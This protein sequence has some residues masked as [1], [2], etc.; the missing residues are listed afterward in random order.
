MSHKGTI[1]IISNTHWH[2]AWQTANSV[3]A[4]LAS[5][6]YKVLFI[7][8]IPKRWPKVM[9][10]SRVIGRAFGNARM[11]GDVEQTIAAGVN[12]ISP[13]TLPDVGSLPHLLNHR[14]FVPRL[15]AKI[16]QQANRPLVVMHALPIKAAVSLQHQLQ[17]DVSIYRCTYDWS[18]DPHSGRILAER[19]LLEQ[20]DM[21]WADCNHNLVR[22]RRVRPEAALM[23]P[24]VELSLFTAVSYTKSNQ[25][26]PLCVYFG[27]LGLSLDYQLLKQIS[28]GYKLRLIGPIRHPLTGFSE[29]TELVGP[30]PHE[31]IPRLI[32]DA[33]VLLLPYNSL[34]H[35]KGVIPAKFFEC[36]ATGKPIVA[37]NL[38]TIDQ[39]RDLVYL[40]HDYESV[41][42]AIEASQHEDS[43]LAARRMACAQANSWEARID[44]M[45]VQIE[46]LLADNQARKLLQ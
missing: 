31:Q 14:F 29:E 33:D 43:R 36:L 18:K 37:T 15:A 30:M 21:A 17:P 26:K 28:H 41:F 42:Q 27:T 6:G 34:P 11:A 4:G 44:Q 23:P 1:I 8:P 10:T 5:R 2:F 24:A 32:R 22:I 7:E 20:V 12:L 3:A 38:T 40:C 13:L 9:D 19:E 46:Q 16:K 35:M 45:E 39:Y 25:S